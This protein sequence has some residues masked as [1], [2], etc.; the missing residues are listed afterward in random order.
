MELRRRSIQSTRARS[1]SRFRSGRG[2]VPDPLCHCEAIA[3]TGRLRLAWWSLSWSPC[4]GSLSAPSAV[5][6]CF[7]VSTGIVELFLWL[8]MSRSSSTP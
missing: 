3:T 7:A 1:R 4:L 6:A 5:C 2:Y 8:G